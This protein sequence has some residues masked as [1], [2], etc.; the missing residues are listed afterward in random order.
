MTVMYVPSDCLY[1]N[2][3]LVTKKKKNNKIELL[4]GIIV[5]G[6]DFGSMHLT[7]FADSLGFLFVE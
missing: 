1:F 5:T 4:L 6:W 7:G 3:M 2:N